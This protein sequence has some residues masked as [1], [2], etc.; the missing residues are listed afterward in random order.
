M[1]FKTLYYN[2]RNLVYYRKARPV[3]GSFLREIKL[4]QCDGVDAVKRTMT[5]SLLASVGLK[6]VDSASETVPW[7]VL[8]SRVQRSWVK[9]VSPYYK[10]GL[11]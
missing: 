2:W 5:N 4:A 6:V 8:L 11:A 7:Y 9:T 10:V 3:S 1:L